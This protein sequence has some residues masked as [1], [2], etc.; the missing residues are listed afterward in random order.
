MHPRF[1]VTDG[2]KREGKKTHT[3]KKDLHNCF[4]KCSFR[5]LKLLRVN[6]DSPAHSPKTEQ[7]I[8]SLDKMIQ[9]TVDKSLSSTKQSGSLRSS[10]LHA[11]Y[12]CVSILKRCGRGQQSC[13]RADG[14]V[15]PVPLIPG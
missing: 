2:L 7:K 15:I 14:F 9:Q 6:Q 1:T 12:C 10:S 5:R 3:H 4:H 13:S 8:L 11:T